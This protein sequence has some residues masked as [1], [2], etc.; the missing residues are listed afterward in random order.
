MIREGTVTAMS[1]ILLNTICPGQTSRPGE[2]ATRQS[3]ISQLEQKWDRRCYGPVTVSPDG[4][5]V[6]TH[7]SPGGKRLLIVIDPHTGELRK[8][9]PSLVDDLDIPWLRHIRLSPDGTSLF[10][11]DYH[12]K[13]IT[14]V[15]VAT[16][17]I[18]YSA[19]LPSMLAMT[20]MGI[21]SDKEIVCLC[22]N[23]AQARSPGRLI[24]V[25][26]ATG[27]ETRG[28][29]LSRDYHLL[30]SSARG[31]LFATACDSDDYRSHD[32]QTMIELWD[33]ATLTVARTIRVSRVSSVVHEPM[34]SFT[35]D[36]GYLATV[37]DKSECRVWDVRSGELAATLKVAFNIDAL[38]FSDDGKMLTI[39]GQEK[40][41]SGSVVRIIANDI[42]QYDWRHDSVNAELRL[43]PTVSGYT[44]CEHMPH[45]EILVLSENVLRCYEV[46]RR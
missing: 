8:Q 4:D 2:T 31:P 35:K 41:V 36:G 46:R 5:V 32:R 18:G 12:A 1:M 30:A 40:F 42:R 13:R 19:A 10:V 23:W 34:M 6:A 11:V 26:M 44:C 17:H 7:A 45:G 37:F 16:G 28:I 22:R 14:R 24:C 25:S 20:S 38:S 15:D 39:V 43:A 29:V 33:K 3:T 9:Y 21:I 27:K